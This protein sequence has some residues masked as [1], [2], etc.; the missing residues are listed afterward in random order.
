MAGLQLGRFLPCVSVTTARH[1]YAE[2]KKIQH[3]LFLYC[4][5]SFKSP[6]DWLISGIEILSVTGVPSVMLELSLI[7]GAVGD[8]GILSVL[9]GAVGDMVC[10][11]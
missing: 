1:V 9:L 5:C 4:H 10:C 2:V 3:S 11:R 7:L 6:S 8:I